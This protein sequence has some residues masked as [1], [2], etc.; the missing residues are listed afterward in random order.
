[1]LQF[2]EI[3]IALAAAGLAVGAIASYMAVSSSMKK[4]HRALEAELSDTAEEL[5]RMVA[6]N[7]SQAN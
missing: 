1:M 7:E 5:G 3:Q 2:D 6:R 4:K